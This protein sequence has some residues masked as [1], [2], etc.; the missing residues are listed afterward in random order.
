MGQLVIHAARVLTP[1]EE[2]CDAAVLVEDHKI[3]AVGRREEFTVPRGAR[4]WDA[5]GLTLTPGFVDVHIHGAGGHDVMEGEP[6]ALRAV[7]RT[8]ARYGTTSLLATTVTA[9]LDATCRSLVAIARFISSDD[10]S[11]G[12]AQY[13]G[14][15]FEGPFLS[16]ARRGVQPAEW[17]IPP[18]AAAFSRLLTAA[19][20]QA[21]ILTLAPEVDG[22]LEIIQSACTSGLV[23]AVGHT[24]A[25][26]AQA[27]A[28][29][30]AGARHAVHVFNAM[31]PFAHRET[32]V[33]GAVLTDARVTCELIADNVHVDPPAMKIL[34]RA[35]GPGGV[36]LVSDAISATGM[37]D[38]DYRLGTFQVTVA[39][40]ICRDARGHLAG[41]TLTLDR[42]LRN[43]VALGVPLADAVR[44]LTLNPAKLL[45]LERSKGAVA[46]GADADL[47]LLDDSLHV[48]GVL[49]RGTPLNQD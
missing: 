16:H 6:D 28:G 43:V 3:A 11:R 37:P 36:I 34:L 42:A 31:R 46:P 18:N 49:L 2:I 10:S 25:T 13:L 26:Y 5:R 35:K 4:E 21:R 17:I 48:R 9:E 32:G 24:D 12:G 20:G 27:M 47:V 23:V 44:M 39:G 38:G 14:I 8:V 45:G 29:I 15:H 7:A 30:N 33:I 22:A 40:G 1:V 41:S 19:S